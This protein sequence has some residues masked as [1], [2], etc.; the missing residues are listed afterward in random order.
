MRT[1]I[2]TQADAR[3]IPPL[4]SGDMLVR[5]STSLLWC[6]MV[7]YFRTCGTE[8]FLLSISRIKNI[9]HHNVILAFCRTVS[10]RNRFNLRQQLRANTFYD[11]SLNPLVFLYE[12]CQSQVKLNSA[13]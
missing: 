4:A 7:S 3:N 10:Y 6:A 2:Q 13:G 5:T 12:A 9:M 8:I 11:F 1:V